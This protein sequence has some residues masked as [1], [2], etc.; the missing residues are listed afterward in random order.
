MLAWEWLAWTQQ[1]LDVVLLTDVARIGGSVRQYV[2]G[3]LVNGDDSTL[4]FGKLKIPQKPHDVVGATVGGF[5][6][7]RVQPIIPVAAAIL[8]RRFCPSCANQATPTLPS[9]P[10]AA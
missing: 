10:P 5:L 7:D 4:T 1:Y 6:R 2:T 9:P 8:L 3:T